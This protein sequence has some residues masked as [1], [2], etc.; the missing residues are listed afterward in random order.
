MVAQ[1]N[2]YMWLLKKADHTWAHTTADLTWYFFHYL[3]FFENIKVSYSIRAR[4]QN[5][6]AVH[7]I[8]YAPCFTECLNSASKLVSRGVFTVRS[9]SRLS[10]FKSISHKGATFSSREAER[11][12]QSG[13]NSSSWS[14]LPEMTRVFNY[15]TTRRDRH[16][17][18]GTT[19]RTDGVEA[20]YIFSQYSS[21]STAVSSVERNTPSL[22]PPFLRP[23]LYPS[24]SLLI[25]SLTLFARI[26]IS[27]RRLVEVGVTCCRIRRQHGIDWTPRVK[28]TQS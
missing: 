17:R 2:D 25:L 11:H 6:S 14:A 12:R 4:Q 23:F 19:E 16:G 3:Y 10:P 22:I 18:V 28:K 8:L 9:S 1:K 21:H 13:G 27:R 15:F 20:I 7:E 24:L 26:P 5:A